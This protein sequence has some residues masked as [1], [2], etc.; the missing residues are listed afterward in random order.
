[1]VSHCITLHLNHKSVLA[2][3]LVF[4]AKKNISFAPYLFGTLCPTHVHTFVVI[5]GWNRCCWGRLIIAKAPNS[6]LTYQHFAHGFRGDSV[7][8]HV[9][10]EFETRPTRNISANSER[11]AFHY[12]TSRAGDFRLRKLKYKCNVVSTRE[13]P[14]RRLS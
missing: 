10:A 13:F 9:T 8:E 7:S 11:L 6:A 12:V 14:L 5:R 3:I 4:S 1:M 2:V